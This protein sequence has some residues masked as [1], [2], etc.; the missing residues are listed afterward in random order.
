MPAARKSWLDF[1]GAGAGCGC[2]DH[3][4]PAIQPV[5]LH[6]TSP[7]AHTGI[8]Q[9][10]QTP[11]HSPRKEQKELTAQFTICSG[12]GAVWLRG[13]EPPFSI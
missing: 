12:Q 6:Q 2:W 7:R 13:S 11:P 9:E 5:S 1:P 3:Q 4:G 8:P 10:L